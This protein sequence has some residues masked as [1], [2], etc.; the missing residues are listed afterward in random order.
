[1]GGGIAVASKAG[2]GTTF[3]VKLPIVVPEKK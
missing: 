1:M 3:L 2:E